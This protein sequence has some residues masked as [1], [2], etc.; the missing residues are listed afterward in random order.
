MLAFI[1]GD[2]SGELNIQ[3]GLAGKIEKNL[4]I[5]MKYQLKIFLCTSKHTKKFQKS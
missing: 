2:R 1:L 4:K 5:K 3:Y